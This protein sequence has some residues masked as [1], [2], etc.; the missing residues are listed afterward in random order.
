MNGLMTLLSVF[1]IFLV[2]SCSSGQIEFLPHEKRLPD[3]KVA[4]L[5]SQDIKLLFAGSGAIFF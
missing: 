4:K 2:I 1:N 3:A 5:Y